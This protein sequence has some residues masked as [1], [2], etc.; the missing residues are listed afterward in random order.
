MPVL[1]IVHAEPSSPSSTRD[2][3]CFTDPED[4]RLWLAAL[5][6]AIYDGLSA[7]EDAARPKRER[8]LSRN[9]AQRKLTVAEEKAECL[10]AAGER[11]LCSAS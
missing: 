8:V 7:G 4:V 5:R 10:L 2:V 11:G 3:V 6:S 1:N 9:E